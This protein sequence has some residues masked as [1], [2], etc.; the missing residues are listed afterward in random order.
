MANILG[1]CQDELEI[2]V[3]ISATC[4]VLCGLQGE[5]V[6]YRKKRVQPDSFDLFDMP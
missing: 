5:L 4:C 3:V 1:E 6:R 2:G